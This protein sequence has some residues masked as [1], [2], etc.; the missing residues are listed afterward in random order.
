MGKIDPSKLPRAYAH[1]A[2]GGKASSDIKISSVAKLSD[3]PPHEGPKKTQAA[4]APTKAD[5]P[6]KAIEEP[7]EDSKEEEEDDVVSNSRGTPLRRP[8][9]NLPI[10]PGQELCP[11][12]TKFGDCQLGP[13][14]RFD[15]SVKKGDD[16]ETQ[17]QQQKET[18]AKRKGAGL[19]GTKSK[20]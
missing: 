9:E 2:Q 16:S 10:R 3:D 7:K 11:F 6:T 12:F 14:C 5:P 20:R 13:Q 18:P 1:L 17:A 4:D 19:G 8:G 15:H